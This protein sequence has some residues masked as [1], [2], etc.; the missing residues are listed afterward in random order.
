LKKVAFHKFSIFLKLI[1]VVVLF[2][3]LLYIGIPLALRF[4]TDV[5]VKRDIPNLMGR[6]E[7]SLINQMGIPPD[8][9]KAV[10]ICRDMGWEMRYESHQ[11]NWASSAYVPKVE[12]L[13][14][15]SDFKTKFFSSDERVTTRFNGHFYSVFKTPKG[16]FI[17]QPHVPGEAFNTE[18][19]IFIITILITIIIL[20]LY[21]ILRWLFKPLKLLTA[22]VEEVGE[23]NYNIRIPV[24]RRDELGELADS[25][26]Q[27]SSKIG[28][29]IKSKEQLLLDVSHEL[30]TPLTRIKLGLEVESSKEKINE[31]V[32]EME[33]M[34]SSLLENY[35]SE[36]A[37]D[38]ISPVKTDAAELIEDTISEY[39]AAPRIKYIKPGKEFIISMDPD[40]VQVVFRNIIDNALK[41]SNGEVVINI[42]EGRNTVDISFKDAGVGISEEDLK[43]IFEPFYRAD[44]SRSKKTEGFGL[45]LSISRKIMDAHKGEIKFK[46]AVNEGTEVILSFKK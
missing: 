23:G 5:N 34:I 20:L 10:Q 13:M 46:S 15:D 29:S 30:R 43:Y 3:A 41:Y 27:M 14:E 16:Y 36:S 21:L 45:G 32:M 39:E 2:G 35:R 24:K 38:A 37:Y 12:D 26:T 44:R 42:K 9:A 28:N 31:D 8:T 1:L 18:K 19:A 4:S 40:K 7:T 11:F 17:I 33:R 6:V 25:I 22:A